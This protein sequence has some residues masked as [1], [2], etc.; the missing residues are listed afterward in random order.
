[1][2]MVWEI[3]YKEVQI[4]HKSKYN[5]NVIPIKSSEIYIFFVNVG[6]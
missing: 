2:F 1:M 4:L 5:F 3:Q 6:K